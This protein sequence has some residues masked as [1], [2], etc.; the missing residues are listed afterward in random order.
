MALR[1]T[2]LCDHQRTR[3]CKQQS[4]DSSGA[5]RQVPWSRVGMCWGGM[6]VGLCIMCVSVLGVCVCVGVGMRSVYMYTY[7]CVWCTFDSVCMCVHIVGELCLQAGE[8]ICSACVYT[9][10]WVGACGHA[11]MPLRESVCLHVSVC[12]QPRLKLRLP[13]V[14]AWPSGQR[15]SVIIN[16]HEVANNGRTIAAVLYDGN[17]HGCMRIYRCVCVCACA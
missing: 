3:R 6:C 14:S 1:S 11:C 17:S 2:W 7:V 15:G 8:R 10:G 13:S 12:P 9:C 4:H 5:K 16:G